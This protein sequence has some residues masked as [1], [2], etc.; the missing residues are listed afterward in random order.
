MDTSA[1]PF[2]A[3]RAAWAR[4]CIGEA[5][6][7]TQRERDR[8]EVDEPALRV[9]VSRIGAGTDCVEREVVR[10]VRNFDL[11]EGEGCEDPRGEADT[12][13]LAQRCERG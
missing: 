8:D 3:A 10:S 5:R 11:G 12:M 9:E 6:D 4:E 2:T 13:G 1:S 7:I